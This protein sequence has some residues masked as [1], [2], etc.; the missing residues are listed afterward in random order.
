MHFFSIE[1]RANIFI[2][3]DI[4]IFHIIIQKIISLVFIIEKLG[5]SKLSF[6]AL[7]HTFA[8][9]ALESGMDIKTLSEVLGHKS[10]TITLNRY[11]HSMM[12]HKQN[13]MDKF[14][15][16]LTKQKR[17]LTPS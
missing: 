5:V 3:M 14:G 12:E 15:V 17:Q 9:R 6:H 11:A 2:L 13:A 8:T 10:A 16:L 4:M 1:F 7:R